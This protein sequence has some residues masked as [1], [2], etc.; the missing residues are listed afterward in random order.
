[1][2]LRSTPPK[3]LSQK[4]VPPILLTPRTSLTPYPAPHSQTSI[5]TFEK[6]KETSIGLPGTPHSKGSQR[7]RGPPSAVPCPWCAPAVFALTPEV[8]CSCEALCIPCTYTDCQHFYQYLSL[9]YF[10]YRSAFK[11][12]VTCRG[13]QDYICKDTIV[14]KGLHYYVYIGQWALLVSYGM[15]NELQCKSYI[16]VSLNT[17]HLC[18]VHITNPF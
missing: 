12:I 9:S 14:T 8:G 13:K 5:S 11:P 3:P 7:T 2:G 16:T 10:R 17:M 15:D 6:D 4:P 18:K 1:M